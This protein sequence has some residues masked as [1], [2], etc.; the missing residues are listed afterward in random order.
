MNYMEEKHAEELVSQGWLTNEAA[1]DLRAKLANLE[2]LYKCRDAEVDALAELNH[3]Q[4]LELEFLRRVHLAAE[5]LYTEAEEYDLPDG[6]GQGAP[7]EYWDALAE[8]FEPETTAI[9]DV[10]NR[11]PNG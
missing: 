9:A 6:L 10:V 4:F 11:T 1:H 8:A 3:Q 7:Q 2:E 5:K